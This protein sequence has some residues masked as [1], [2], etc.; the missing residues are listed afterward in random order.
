[1]VA[2]KARK[3]ASGVSPISGVAPPKEYQFGAKNGNPRHN[4]AW[5]KEDTARYKLERMYELTQEQVVAIA[6]DKDAPLFERRLA[7]SLLKENDFSVS[8]RMMN[9]TYGAPKENKEVE[10]HAEVSNIN[11]NVRRY[12]NKE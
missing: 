1:M 11:L 9:Q 7:R 8:E 2:D 10:M 6:N 12:D 5:R 4:G 3:L